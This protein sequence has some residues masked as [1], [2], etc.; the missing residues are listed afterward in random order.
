VLARDAGR[1]AGLAGEPGD[2]LGLVGR[3]GPQELE[4]HV[5]GE[6]PLAGGEDDAHAA[7]AEL[8]GDLELAGDHVADLERLQLPLLRVK[9]PPS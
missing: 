5:P 9:A 8:P 6:L 3:R 1:G 4:R 2:A 7:A